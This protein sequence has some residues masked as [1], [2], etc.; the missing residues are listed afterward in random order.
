MIFFKKKL[1]APKDPIERS[2]WAAEDSIRML[3]TLPQ[4]HLSNEKYEY[5]VRNCGSA[6]GYIITRIALLQRAKHDTIQARSELTRIIPFLDHIDDAIEKAQVKGLSDSNFVYVSNLDYPF[7][8][9]LLAGD[10]VRAE[11]LARS[12]FL[13]VVIDSADHGACPDDEIPRMLAAAILDD[14]KKFSHHRKR[15]DEGCGLDRFFTVYFRYDRLLVPVFERDADA[16]NRA[17]VEE[18]QLFLARA[19]DK[20]VNHPQTIDAM[21]ENNDRVF[22]VWAVAIANLAHHRGMRVTHSSEVIPTDV[23]LASENE[24]SS[25]AL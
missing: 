4:E 17:L 5:V 15:Y 19:K 24:G 20:R 2:L 18:E 9:T 12:S 1:T 13:K 16:F 14:A 25:L 6:I 21:L 23:Y 3:D 22:D 8:G 10:W 11:R 7:V